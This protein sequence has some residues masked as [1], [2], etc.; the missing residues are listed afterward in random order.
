MAYDLET[1]F[2]SSSNVH[3]EEER[4]R[5]FLV[6]TGGEIEPITE[7][8]TKNRCD[9]WLTAEAGAHAART[10]PEWNEA[11]LGIERRVRPFRL[12]TNV[13]WH[14]EGMS[15]RPVVVLERNMKSVDFVPNLVFWMHPLVRD[16]HE[17]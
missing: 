7:Q 11:F 4:E 8:K 15:I 1:L 5:A 12:W 16:S 10:D 3:P 14:T 13:R 6:R 9:T 17:I 2:L